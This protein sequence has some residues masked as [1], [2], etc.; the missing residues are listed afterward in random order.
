MKQQFPKHDYQAK[1]GSVPERR[2]TDVGTLTFT[3]ASCLES[4]SRLL[5][6]RRNQM[7]PGCPNKAA[8][9]GRPHVVLSGQHQRAEAVW[10]E[11]QDAQVAASESED[12][13]RTIPK[14]QCAEITTKAGKSLR[15]HLPEWKTL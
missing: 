10:R 1:K 3:T 14:E 12:G 6:G 13:E 15:S 11:L 7:E 4:F 8:R 9:Q 2:E 5:C